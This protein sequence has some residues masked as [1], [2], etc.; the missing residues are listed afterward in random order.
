MFEVLN[1]RYDDC[2]KVVKHVCEAPDTRSTLWSTWSSQSSEASDHILYLAR[3]SLNHIKI[4]QPGRAN[5]RHILFK[6]DKF[7]LVR[8]HSIISA[9]GSKVYIRHL[10]LLH[11]CKII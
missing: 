2:C 1:G 10:S 4:A 5:A 7:K 3:P 11:K 9:F 6:C 8:G